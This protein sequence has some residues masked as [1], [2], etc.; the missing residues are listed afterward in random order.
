M[1]AYI[2]PLAA[3]ILASLSGCQQER[4]VPTAK[5]SARPKGQVVTEPAATPDSITSGR[6]GVVRDLA[7]ETRGDMKI[8]TIETL[9]P[10][11][12][13][14]AVVGFRRTWNDTVPPGGTSAAQLVLVDFT[15]T[16]TGDEAVTLMEHEN[17]RPANRFELVSYGLLHSSERATDTV[18]ELGSWTMDTATGEVLDISSPRMIM[19]IAPKETNGYSVILRYYS[20]EWAPGGTRFLAVRKS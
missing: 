10:M 13:D 5:P 9:P 11:I 17:L 16:V 7:V 3:F 6:T 19:V 4:S 14:P 8:T 1:K 2:V 15:R 18:A 20:A 12:I